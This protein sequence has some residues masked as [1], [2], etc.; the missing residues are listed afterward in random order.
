MCSC[1]HHWWPS[2]TIF[3]F[4]YHVYIPLSQVPLGG[5]S[6]SVARAASTGGVKEGGQTEVRVP[7]FP[8]QSGAVAPRKGPA[9]NTWPSERLRP[10]VRLFFD[11]Y[12]HEEGI[13]SGQK[14][15]LVAHLH[16]RKPHSISTVQ[17]NGSL[18]VAPCTFSASR[19]V[20][21]W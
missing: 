5:I 12:P 6:G 7:L 8:C 10:Q 9:P 14:S 17:K 3:I 18:Q 4:T 21:S 20:V 15:R 16:L 13:T 1:T 11:K 2:S 19:V